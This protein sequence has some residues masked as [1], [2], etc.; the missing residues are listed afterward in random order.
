VASSASAR[1]QCS[2]AFRKSPGC[3]SSES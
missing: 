3:R 2:T 1:S